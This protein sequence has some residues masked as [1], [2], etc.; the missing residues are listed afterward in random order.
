MNIL[1]I[2]AGHALRQLISLY[3]EVPSKSPA[4]SRKRPLLVLPMIIWKF[5][6]MASPPFWISESN[7]PIPNELVIFIR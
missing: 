1:G 5:D 2:S 3:A 7:A 4:K 6:D